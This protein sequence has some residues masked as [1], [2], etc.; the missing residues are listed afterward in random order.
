M[1]HP[2]VEKWLPHREDMVLLDEVVHVGEDGAI[3]KVNIKP[4]TQF[5]KDGR[6]PAW[7]G[8]EYMAQTMAAYSGGLSLQNSEEVSL[9][10]LLG[11][12]RYTT[13]LSHFN[14]G[15]EL[16]IRIKP[17]MVHDAISNFDCVIELNSDEVATAALTAYKPDE[18]MLE[19]MKS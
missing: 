9:A 13:K 15:D 16:I 7:V 14:V 2:D 10:F 6:V 18:K 8:I 5:C 12:R 3:A 17:A 1:G 4:E 11:S 19:G